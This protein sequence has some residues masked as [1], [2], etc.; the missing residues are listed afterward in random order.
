[1]K[2]FEEQTDH[3]RQLEFSNHYIFEISILP[4]KMNRLENK[5]VCPEIS[6]NDI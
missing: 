2:Q 4:A 6:F 1:M 5:R 3:L